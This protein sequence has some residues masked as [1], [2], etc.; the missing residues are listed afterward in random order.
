[1]ESSK[2][3][4]NKPLNNIDLRKVLSEME[5]DYE[6]MK[7]NISNYEKDYDNTINSLSTDDIEKIQSNNFKNI[8]E[9]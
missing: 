8:N 5:T 2:T 4:I 9:L 1:M 6:K 7:I 3:G